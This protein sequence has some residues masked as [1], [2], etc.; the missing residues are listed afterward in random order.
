M[1]RPSLSPFL[2]NFIELRC[3][4]P[5]NRTLNS[6]AIERCLIQCHKGGLKFLL[7]LRVILSSIEAG[8]RFRFVMKVITRHK[9]SFL[10]FSSEEW[11]SVEDDKEMLVDRE[12]P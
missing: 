8:R 11:L 3:L 5:F 9:P 1:T 2:D 12:G 7:N 4:L 10:S 6:E